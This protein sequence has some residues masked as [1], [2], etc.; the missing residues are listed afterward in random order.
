MKREINLRAIYNS[1][2]GRGRHIS[3]AA[4]IMV[5]FLSLALFAQSRE[6]A[7]PASIMGTV[8]IEIPSAGGTVRVV[9]PDDIR[10]GDTISGTVYFPAKGVVEGEVVEVKTV[11]GEV[12][13]VKSNGPGDK[14]LKFVVPAGMAS[15]PFLLKSAS[16]KHIG[17]AVL[18]VNDKFSGNIPTQLGSFTSDK[19]SGNIP[20]QLGSDRRTGALIAADYNFAPPRLG[21]TGRNLSIPGNFDGSAGS[22]SV[23][24]GGRQLPVIAESPRKSVVQ[25]PADSAIGPSRLTVSEGRGPSQTSPINVVS[26]ELKADKLNLMKGE[27]TTLHVN[28]AGLQ[29]LT[30]GDARLLLQN[31]SPQVV[32]LSFSR[33]YD[34]SGNTSGIRTVGDGKVNINE[35]GSVAYTETLTGVSPGAFAVNALLFAPPPRQAKDKKKEKEEET[36]DPNSLRG[37]L[38]AIAKLKRDAA[39]A[40]TNTD[41][42]HDLEDNAAKLEGNVNNKTN[43]DD[44]GGTKYLEN[45]LKILKDEKVEL[46]KKLV[47]VGDKSEAGKKII[48]AKSAIDEAVGIVEAKIAEREAAKKKKK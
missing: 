22:T 19:F 40:A 13:A 42:K 28:L 23:N 34:R 27:K 24:I 1:I 39:N 20:T 21:Q 46:D 33:G 32:D 30:G 37:R 16:G 7:D 11:E 26:V 43:W 18:N 44:K 47:Q 4:A 31:L 15:I 9:L 5:L 29:G 25:I 3:A 2:I 36:I 10:A 6:G 38:K 48:E 45:L 35:T 41:A 12:V 14:M 8:T 17:T